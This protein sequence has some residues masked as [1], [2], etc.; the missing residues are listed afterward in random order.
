MSKHA[1]KTPGRQQGFVLVTALILML[2]VGMV[3]MSSFERS[4]TEQR[5][6]SGSLPQ[7]SLQAAAEAG[8]HRARVR[9]STTERSGSEQSV[10]R[11]FVD[12][13]FSSPS[14]LEPFLYPDGQSKGASKDNSVAVQISDDQDLAFWWLDLD[15]LNDFCEDYDDEGYDYPSIQIV[16]R[17]YAGDPENPRA[18]AAVAGTLF[19]RPDP[20]EDDSIY[21]Q[22][23]GLLVFNEPECGGQGQGQGQG[24][25]IGHR[26]GGGSGGSM[27]NCDSYEPVGSIDESALAN[28]KSS[29]LSQNKGAFNAAGFNPSLIPEGSDPYTVVLTGDADVVFDF[30]DRDRQINIVMEGSGSLTINSKGGGQNMYTGVVYA[31]NSH[32]LLDSGQGGTH[33]TASVIAENLTMPNGSRLYYLDDLPNMLGTNPAMDFDFDY[34]YD[35]ESN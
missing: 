26:P 5:G 29:L 14:Q 7:A 17:A 8:L 35:L 30:G 20:E 33:I 28:I 24:A 9:V 21:K 12:N 4:G 22:K 25:R 10:C 1:S 2:L 16:S 6:A 27:S 15:E 3:V 19:F 13:E 23:N 32:V 11:D 34:D 18:R 31:P